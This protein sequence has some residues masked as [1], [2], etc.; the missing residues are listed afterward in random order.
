MKTRSVPRHRTWAN[1]RVR[2]I[3][4]GLPPTATVCA[5]RLFDASTMWTAFSRE[6]RISPHRPSSVKRIGPSPDAARIVAVASWLVPSTTVTVP[7]CP[8]ATKSAR[9]A[10]E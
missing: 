3:W 7:A 1:P 10:A 2:A 9:A 5:S 4:Y 8:S 6:L